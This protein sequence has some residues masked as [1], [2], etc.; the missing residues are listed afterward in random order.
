MHNGVCDIPWKR[1][2]FSWMKDQ[3]RVGRGS[4]DF[5]T[6]NMF[7]FGFV[8]I[9]ERDFWEGWNVNTRNESEK[10]KQNS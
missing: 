4:T 9:Q 7:D 6:G 10:K 8:H 5:S 3:E 2:K 1:R